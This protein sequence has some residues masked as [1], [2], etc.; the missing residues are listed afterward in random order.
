LSSGMLRRIVWQKFTDVSEMLAASII[1]AMNRD[2]HPRRQ[3]SSYSPPWELEI[4]H[5]KPYYGGIPKELNIF[6]FQ[7]G[8]PSTQIPCRYK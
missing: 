6:S 1:R 4:L 2:T 3:S 7:T 8:S 5:R